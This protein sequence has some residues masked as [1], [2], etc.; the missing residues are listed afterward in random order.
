MNKIEIGKRLIELRGE[1]PREKVCV[2]L[3]ISF[4]ALQSYELGLK[5]PKDETKIKISEYYK[6]SVEDIFFR[7][8]DT[9]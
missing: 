9:K 8:K 1:T 4:S 2:D 7:T 3:N 6:T 5:I